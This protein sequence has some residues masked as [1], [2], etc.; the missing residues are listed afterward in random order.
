MRKAWNKGLTAETDERVK[1]YSESRKGVKRPNTSKALIGHVCTE[2]TRKKISLANTGRKHKPRSE[3]TRKKLRLVHLGKKKTKESVSKRL[4]TIAH[5]DVYTGTNNPN[6]KGGITYI[7][8]NCDY[9]N[10]LTK[11]KR[12]N[13][14][15]SENHFCSRKCQGIWYS[16]NKTGENNHNYKG[17]YTTYKCAMCNVEKTIKIP[18]YMKYENHFCSKLC[19]DKHQEE[20]GLT[21]GKNNGNWLGG[22]SFDPYSSEWNKK[23]KMQIIKRDKNRCQECFRH[24]SELAPIK[25]KNYRLVVHHIDYNKKNCS[26]DNLITLCMSC[27]AQTN[28][29]RDDWLNYFQ[30]RIRGEL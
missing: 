4:K 14:N 2:E 11:G 24:E 6:Y 28:F 27:H 16:I 20:F 18:E 23:L 13:Y 10:K 7:E 22:K 1:K 3:E 8:F 30:K 15:R 12:C 9:C 29:K 21:T 26:Q 5:K 17:N 19:K 25:N